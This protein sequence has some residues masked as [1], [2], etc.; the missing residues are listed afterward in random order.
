[1]LIYIKKPQNKR[2]VTLYNYILKSS[3]KIQKIRINT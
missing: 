2:N 3:K 1:M